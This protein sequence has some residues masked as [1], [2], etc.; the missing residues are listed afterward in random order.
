MTQ[1]YSITS[2][3]GPSIGSSIRN[4]MKLVI[5]SG[6]VDLKYYPRV[7]L[8]DFISAIG[9]PFRIYEN[10]RFNDKIYTT[11]LKTPPLF[12]LGHWRSG[13][14]YIHNLMCQD[15]QFGYITML[16]AAFPKS[17]ISNNFF[18]WIMKKLMP[19]KR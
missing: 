3:L 15:P 9:I 18:K 19:K 17:F 11:D 6:S 16:N 1:K 13:T 2:K 10:L 4:W 14:T 7:I 12:I 8:V 5:S